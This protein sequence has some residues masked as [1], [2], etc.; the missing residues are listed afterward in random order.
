MHMSCS[1]NLIATLENIKANHYE[2][3]LQ[4]M[5]LNNLEMQLSSY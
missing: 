4:H 1:F 3:E 2:P 5:T